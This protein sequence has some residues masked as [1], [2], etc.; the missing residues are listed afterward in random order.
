MSELTINQ[1]FHHIADLIEDSFIKYAHNTAYSCLGQSLTFADIDEKSK[2]FAHWLQQQS[3][4]AVGDRIAI[5]L[6][7]LIQ[8]PI[9]AYGAL[10]AGLILVNTNPL[11]TERE[12]TH[13]FKDAGVKAI[14]ILEDL[15]PKLNHVLPQTDIELVVT[16]A[17]TDLLTGANG[18]QGDHIGLNQ[19]LTDYSG[20]ALTSRPAGSLDDLCVL[21]Y[22]GGTTGVAKGACLSHRNL[23]A[24]TQQCLL[25]LGDKCNAGEEIFISPLPLYHIYAFTVNLLLFFSQGNHSV[26]IP[27]PR[28]LKAMVMAM[29]PYPFTGMS[30]INTLFVG[31]SSVAEFRALDFSHLRLTLAGGSATTE[32]AMDTWQAVT[33]CTISEGYGLSETSP[34]LCLNK[35]GEETLGSVGQPLTNT[36]IQ[37]R[38]QDNKP[39]KQGEI[40]V[41]GPQVMSGYWQ[42]EEETNNAFTVDGYFKTGDVGVEL[43]NGCIKIVDRLKDMIIVSGFNV[44]P[45]EV[46]AVLV[47]HPDVIEA[48]VIGELDDRT[49]EKVSAYVAVKRDVSVAALSAFCAEQL[50]AYKVPKKITLMDELPKSTVGK[51]LRRALR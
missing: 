23:I 27:N 22:T 12:M 3:K 16:T 35:P 4:L 32:T 1:D 39:A 36:D 37:L 26:L 7:N 28:D 20:E 41:R 10:R 31:L 25:R 11:Y 15:V 2:A 46:E 50:T 19:I 48:A 42:R 6:P 21:Q 8:Y 18:T 29:K 24:N 17:A 9:V 30:G 40:V 14:V 47:K 5:Q 51:I 13:Q 38:D 49:G 33:G 45:N 44:Y 43:D 34:V